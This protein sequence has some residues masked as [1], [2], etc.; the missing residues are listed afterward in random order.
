MF[1]VEHFAE[2]FQVFHGEH[3]ANFS[4][5]YLAPSRSIYN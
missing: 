1:H 4:C 3:S 2:T 5:R